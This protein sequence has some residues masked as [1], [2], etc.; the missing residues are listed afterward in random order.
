LR[1]WRYKFDVTENVL[2]L[3]LVKSGKSQG[4][5][6]EPL[7]DARLV[8]AVRS[9]NSAMAGPFY[10]RTRPI[11]ARTVHRLLGASDSD[12][13]DLVQVASIELLHS[14]D[15]FRGECSLDTWTS[16]IAANVVY[17]HI[18]RRGLERTIF[19]PELAADDVPQTAHQRPVLRGMVERVMQHLGRMVHERAW[20]LLLHDVHGYS[21]DEVANIT[22]ATVAAAQSRLV[23]GRHELHE[24]IA[25][26]P[27]LAGGLDVLEDQS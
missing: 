19:A 8:A 1:R 13:D 5:S 15:R 23:R 25:S 3:R 18:R 7:D 10:D 26:D 22:G 27:D 20:T 17:K 4:S 9:G 2:K 11:V 6:P 16:T 24:R 12:F 21:L 14:L